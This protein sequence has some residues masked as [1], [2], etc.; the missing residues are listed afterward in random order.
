MESIELLY[1][2]AKADAVELEMISEKE[3]NEIRKKNGLPTRELYGPEV[4]STQAVLAKV[5]RQKYYEKA[6]EE[7]KKLADSVRTTERQLY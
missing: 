2:V 1:Q 3:Y 4:M 7:E 5:N 6:L